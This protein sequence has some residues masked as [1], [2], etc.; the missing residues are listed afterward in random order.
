MI[1]QR[2]ERARQALDRLELA[3]PARSVLAAL[4]ETATARHA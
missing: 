4:V 3:D 2:A 1:D